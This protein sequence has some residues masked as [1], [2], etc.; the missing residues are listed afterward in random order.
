M[1]LTELQKHL[2]QV[3]LRVTQRLGE[4]AINSLVPRTPVKTGLHRGNWRANVGEPKGERFDT[5]DPDGGATI[6]A[7]MEVIRNL[8][9]GDVLVLENSGPAISLLENG[10]SQQAPNGFV[11]I[12]Q[13]ELRAQVGQIYRE[14]MA[15]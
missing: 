13:A 8:Q 1:R 14:E 3:G 7:A 10:S 15:K 11:R 2:E 6:S 4:K 9:P 5:L 12:T